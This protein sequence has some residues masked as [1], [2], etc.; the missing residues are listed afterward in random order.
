[1]ERN[2]SPEMLGES[3]THRIVVTQRAHY[4]RWWAI[5]DARTEPGPMSMGEMCYVESYSC[6]C[7]RRGVM[8]MASY[9][10]GARCA[11]SADIDGL[12]LISSRPHANEHTRKP[13]SGDLDC[14]HSARRNQYAVVGRP[15]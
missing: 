8:A 10:D 4:A 3:V 11:R 1:M 15:I 9:P 7:L 2:R 6:F 12:R 14:D 5:R 13:A